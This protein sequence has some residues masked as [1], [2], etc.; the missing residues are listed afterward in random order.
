MILAWWR[1]RRRRRALAH[2]FPEE[3]DRIL[4]QNVA[5]VRR[6]SPD[7]LERL[8]NKLK[9]FIAEK[10]W[11]GC[12]GLEITDEIKVTIA[13]QACLLVLGF[14]DECFDHLQSVLVYPGEYVAEEK[15]YRP[16]GV[17]VETASPRFGE[18][19]YRGPVILS[20]PSVLDGGRTP[21]SGGNVVFHEF[22]HVLD[23]QDSFVDGTPSLETREHS[24]RWSEV[25][26]EEYNQLSRQAERGRT[27]LLDHYGT[28]NE[29][30]FFA[31]STECFF[32]RSVE[33]SR[34]HSNLYQLFCEFYCQDPAARVSVTQ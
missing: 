20:W 24:Q 29:A 12:N 16:G 4:Q 5:H 1:R 33:L 26:T 28:I 2:P 8:R 32:E 14:E 7:E 13:G 22:A 19:W 10:Y 34:Q 11:E 25:M 31:V 21:E 23:M 18:A 6:L 27:G 30:E 3:W 15:T 9:I 17:V